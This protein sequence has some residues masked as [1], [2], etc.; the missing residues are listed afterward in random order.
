MLREGERMKKKYFCVK[1]DKYIPEKEVEQ[2]GIVPF[3]PFSG[4]VEKLHKDYG[5]R[6]WTE[7]TDCFNPED[8]KE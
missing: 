5:G 2:H 1:C 6:V 8:V 7:H 4:T 3:M